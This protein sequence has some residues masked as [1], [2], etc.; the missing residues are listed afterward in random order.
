MSEEE[1]VEKSF[2]QA[3]YKAGDQVG[4]WDQDRWIPVT[5]EKVGDFTDI[6]MLQGYQ[7]ITI[8]GE[9]HYV[10]FGSETEQLRGPKIEPPKDEI[11]VL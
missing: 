2:P 6:S 1:I 8:T 5:I 3:L 9:K 4:F 7:I 10:A 11:K